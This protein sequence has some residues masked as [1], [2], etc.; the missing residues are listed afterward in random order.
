MTENI[1]SKYCSWGI[2]LSVSCL[3]LAFMPDVGPAYYLIMIFTLFIGVF[4]RTNQFNIR[5]V[6]FVG[7][8]AVSLIVN[9]TAG[10]FRTWERWCL[11]IVVTGVLS[12][13]LQNTF[14]NELRLSLLNKAIWL[15]L[16][17][18]VLSFFAYFLGI[19]LSVRINKTEI[20]YFGGITINSMLLAPVAGLSFI[21]LLARLLSG[22]YRGKNPLYLYAI[23]AGLIMCFVVLLLTGSRG[24][25]GATA[26]SSVFVFFKCNRR[27]FVKF[28]LCLSLAC[29][30]VGASY[31]LWKPYAEAIE[32][33]Q[34]GN[35]ESGGTTSSRD[36]KWKARIKEFQSSP[37]FGIGFSTVAL[38]HTD[39]YTSTGIIET[40]TSWGGLL[41]MVG[42][43]GF[44]PFISLWIDYLWFLF[45]EET[46]L[47]YS[48]LLGAILCWFSVHMLA[49]G[50][51]VAGGSFL[52]FLLWLAIGAA[53]AYREKICESEIELISEEDEE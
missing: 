51:V 10:I 14:F 31:T 3:L 19:D 36:L 48:G 40:G 28:I 50:Y 34:K 9:E 30:L 35:I 39:D 4:Q 15:S 25:L 1:S 53:A 29:A 17:A 32:R 2:V 5:M 38:E 47:Y 42:L 49:E 45:K 6:L 26:V 16:I 7:I 21:H 20:I 18:T 43:L 44:L 52:C 8:C 27:N 41:A 12:P 11:F 46:N 24:A 33:K 37:F 22:Q 13:L 23:I